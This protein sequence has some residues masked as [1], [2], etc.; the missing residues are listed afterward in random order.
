MTRRH[1]PPVIVR[2]VLVLVACTALTGV[3][4]GSAGLAAE[5]TASSS[6]VD[7]GGVAEL[8]QQ[9]NDDRG[10]TRL[11]LLLSPT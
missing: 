1:V 11:V 10:N 3:A 4:P 9:F 7:L 2:A 6:L 8:Q 5:Q